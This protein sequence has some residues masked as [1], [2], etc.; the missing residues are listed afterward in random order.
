MTVKSTGAHALSGLVAKRSEIAG[1]IDA[2][3]EK[4]RQL[5]VDLDHVDAAI[6]LFNPDYDIA[7]IRTRPNHPAQIARRGDSIRM[8]LDLLREATEPLSTKQITLQ[9]MAIR[10][11]NTLDDALVL[12]MTRR[13]GASLRSYKANGALRSIRDGRYGKYDLWEIVR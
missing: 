4:L 7:S 12:M 11:L 3:R 10:G 5:I 6:R 8:I 13:V 9:V 2:V 1:E